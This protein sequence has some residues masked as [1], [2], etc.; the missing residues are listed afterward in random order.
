MTKFLLTL[1][2]VVSYPGTS[3]DAV[4]GNAQTDQ[5]K[6]QA[7]A[8]YMVRYSK[9]CHVGKCIGDFEGIGYGGSHPNISTCKPSS[10]MQLTGDAVAIDKYGKWVRV[11]AWRRISKNYYV[12]Y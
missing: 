10:K 3:G 9:Y 7:E 6:C 5:E 1:I 4:W 12:T 11:R 8:D 2:A